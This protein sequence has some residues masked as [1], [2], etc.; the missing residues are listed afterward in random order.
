MDMEFQGQQNQTNAL[1]SAGAVSTTPGE[2]SSST[3]SGGV[4]EVLCTQKNSESRD[5]L[6]VDRYRVQSGCPL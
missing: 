5:Y 3:S 4:K 6:S 2:L 1:K